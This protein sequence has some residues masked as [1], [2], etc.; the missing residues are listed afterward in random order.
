MTLPEE[1]RTEKEEGEKEEEEWREK[2]KE[3]FIFFFFK[4]QRGGGGRGQGQTRKG[5]RRALAE[6]TQIVLSHSSPDSLLSGVPY[7]LLIWPWL[8]PQPKSSTSETL[9]YLIVLLSLP[10]VFPLRK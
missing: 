4:G 1:G 7:R 10:L 2:W 8:P 5:T 6:I 3:G 9:S